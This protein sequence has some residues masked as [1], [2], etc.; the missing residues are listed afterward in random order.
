ML[1]DEQLDSKLHKIQGYA[2]Q[3][4]KEGG[5]PRSSAIAMLVFALIGWCASLE[6]IMS[7]KTRLTQ[8]D[9]QLG[10][11][12]NSLIGCGKWVGA[13]QNE[14]FFGISNSVLGLAFFS[15]I[16]ALALVLT[17]GGRLPRL[18]WQALCAA[19]SFGMVWVLW[20]QYQSFF[21]ERSICPYCFI[22]WLVT[23][24]LF[25]IVWARALQSG[26]WGT[27]GESLGRFAARNHIA[28]VAL[29]YIALL[30]FILIWFWDTWAHMLGI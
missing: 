14:V 23:I 30:G 21:V 24:A 26:H 19:L 18:L 5:L 27:R 3:E 12:I 2:C 8:P 29:C 6:L 11:D 22:T 20:F 15:G 1:T 28:I 25:V 7:E 4:Q 17:M 16:I 13:W 9:A 10:C